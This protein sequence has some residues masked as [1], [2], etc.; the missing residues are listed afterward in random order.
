MRGLALRISLP[1]PPHP[2]A[3][4]FS[5]AGRRNK[6]HGLALCGKNGIF[7]NQPLSNTRQQV[8]ETYLFRPAQL[9]FGR[10]TISATLSFFGTIFRS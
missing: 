6:R 1:L 7:L 10:Q 9:A 3:A 8:E 4:D 5:P 2:A